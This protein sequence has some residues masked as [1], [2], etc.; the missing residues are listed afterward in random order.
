[1]K[2]DGHSTGVSCS[3]QVVGKRPKRLPRLIVN[4]SAGE[5]H[6]RWEPEVHER[7]LCAVAFLV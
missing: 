7:E 6:S 3:I 4:A 5:K 2:P 1:M